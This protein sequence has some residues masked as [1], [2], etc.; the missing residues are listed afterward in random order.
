MEHKM[1]TIH[2]MKAAAYLPLF[3]LHNEQMAIRTFS[4]C[5]NDKAHA[6]GMHPE[7]Y[8]LWQVGIF[9]DKTGEIKYITPHIS[10]GKGN[11]FVAETKQEAHFP[12]VEQ[13]N[14]SM[15]LSK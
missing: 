1:F 15:E 4:D 7:D 9:N 14:K 8:S 6:F 13:L 2:D 5:C 3:L 10:H 11:E 12:T